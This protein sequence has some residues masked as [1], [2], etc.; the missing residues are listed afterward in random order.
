MGP[1]G[2]LLTTGVIYPTAPHCRTAEAEERMSEWVR[3]Y[4]VTAIAIGNGTASRETE[5]LAAW[6]KTL[7]RP[8]VPPIRL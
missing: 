6:L 3:R 7:P 8:P 1:T 2:R 5:Q 4:K